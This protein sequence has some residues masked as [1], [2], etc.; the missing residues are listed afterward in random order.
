[1][2]NTRSVGPVWLPVSGIHPA[3]TLHDGL[4]PEPGNAT[5]GGVPAPS[6]NPAAH[7]G[8]GFAGTEG[9]SPPTFSQPCQAQIPGFW[10]ERS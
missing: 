6:T 7:P 9:A 8:K 1:M 2:L 3:E 5:P 10:P 4:R